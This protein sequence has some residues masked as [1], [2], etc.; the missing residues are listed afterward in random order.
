V[1]CDVRNILSVRGIINE[2]YTESDD[3]KWDA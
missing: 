1:N 3:G 2:Y